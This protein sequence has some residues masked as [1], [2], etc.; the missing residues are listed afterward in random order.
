MRV[1]AC[2]DKDGMTRVLRS[3]NEPTC[4]DRFDSD[5]PRR[6]LPLSGQEAERICST[7]APGTF[8]ELKKL[9]VVSGEYE[10]VEVP[11]VPTLKEEFEAFAEEFGKISPRMACDNPKKWDSICRLYARMHEAAD[12]EPAPKYDE[13]LIDELLEV[14]K[15]VPVSLNSLV[16]ANLKFED[17]TNRRAAEILQALKRAKGGKQ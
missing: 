11:K 15:R 13:A 4:P 5:G 1:F 8:R 7:L 3:N 6:Q 12:R 14:G 16:G 10:F 2:K 17:S 9:D